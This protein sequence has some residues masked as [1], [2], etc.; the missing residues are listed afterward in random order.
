[1]ITI[2]GC[3][4]RNKDGKYLLVQ[5]KQKRVYGLWN[6][7][8]GY[9][10]AGESDRQAAIRETKEE[11]GLTVELID[12]PVHMYE[13]IDKQKRYLAYRTSSY[14]GVLKVQSSEILDAKWL[15][16]DEIESLWQHNLIREPWVYDALRKAEHENTRN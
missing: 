13:N 9:A 1:M 14:V 12:Q 10:D 11:V 15:D 6:I 8:A 16:F 5:E 3:I 7:P 4:V 2:A